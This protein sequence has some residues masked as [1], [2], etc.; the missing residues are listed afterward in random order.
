V[1]MPGGFFMPRGN[2]MAKLR[3]GLQEKLLL[4]IDEVAAVLGIG[5]DLVYRLLL[6]IDPN[7][8]KPR[9]HSVR[10]GRRRMVSRHALEVFIIQEGQ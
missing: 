6:D 9:L 10:I 3:V 7:M 2:G 1:V 5:R 8:G 4:N